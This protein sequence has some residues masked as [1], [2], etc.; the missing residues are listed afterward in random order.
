MTLSIEWSNAEKKLA[1][2][3]YER[4]LQVEKV[5]LVAEFKAR[6]Q[7]A[8]D[9]DSVWEIRDWLN[10]RQREIER[11]YDFRYSQ[12]LHVFAALIIRGRLR[13]QDLDGLD[14]DKLAKIQLIVELS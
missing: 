9:V 5:A 3:A 4:A 14:G 8:E 13:I 6:A 10:E 2:S 12:L 7:K 11:T 1:R